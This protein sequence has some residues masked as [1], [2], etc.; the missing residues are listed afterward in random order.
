MRKFEVEPPEGV[1]ADY[2]VLLAAVKALQAAGKLPKEPTQEQRASW[3]YGQTKLE[4]ALVTREDAAKAA[5]RPAH[6]A[7]KATA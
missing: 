4:N 3:A 6:C 2:D 7:T 1:A 5:A